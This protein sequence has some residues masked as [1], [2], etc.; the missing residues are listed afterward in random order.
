MHKPLNKQQSFLE[1]VF[2]P[3]YFSSGQSID[4]LLPF[5]PISIKKNK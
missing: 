2:A 1:G 3:Q 5:A 4:F